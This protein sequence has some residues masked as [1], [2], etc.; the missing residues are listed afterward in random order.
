MS[1]VQFFIGVA[2]QGQHIGEER[3]PVWSRCLMRQSCSTAVLCRGSGIISFFIII[4]CTAVIFES[5][6]IF[7]EFCMCSLT[8]V[9]FSGLFFNVGQCFIAVMESIVEKKLFCNILL[10]WN[11]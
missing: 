10:F 2:T 8:V 4:V 5:F 7:M 3:M 6:C 11:C 1:F 9:K